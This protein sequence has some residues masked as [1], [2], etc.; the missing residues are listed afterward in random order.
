M[1]YNKGIKDKLQSF[2]N[3]KNVPHILFNGSCGSGKRTIVNNFV[4]NIYNNDRE[5]IKNYTMFAD[6]AHG[7]GIKFIR[8]EIKFFAKTNIK[9]KDTGQFKTIIIANADKLTIDAQSALRRCI[10]VF[11]H[12]TRFFIIIENKY[13]LLKPILSRLCEIYVPYKRF[14]KKNINP[15]NNVKKNNKTIINND[16][17]VNFFNKNEPCLLLDTSAID[18]KH[19]NN[20]KTILYCKDIPYSIENI[21]YLSKELYEK[22]YSG[23]DIMKFIENNNNSVKQEDLLDKYTLLMDI[24]KVK[25]E[26]RYEQLFM[27]YILSR[28]VDLNI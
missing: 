7:K 25:S 15:K 20:I 10:E 21:A 22:G 28:I 24:Y 8:D 1:N 6:C 14:K 16:K 23:L 2:I 11:S 17:D 9:Y 26:F 3:N 5:L 12:N 13:T 27:A 18:K 19:I 4:S